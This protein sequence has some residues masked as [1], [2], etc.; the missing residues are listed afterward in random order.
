MWIETGHMSTLLL[1]E[2]S[3]NEFFIAK[4]IDASDHV[5]YIPGSFKDV[6]VCNWIS[7][8]RPTFLP[9]SF[10]NFMAELCKN[11]LPM[12]VLRKFVQSYLE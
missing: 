4:S 1:L 12:T 11:F 9:L 7:S 2:N 6:H 5:R 8:D 3:F 10:D